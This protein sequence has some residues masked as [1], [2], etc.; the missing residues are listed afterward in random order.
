MKLGTLFV[1]MITGSVL[2][3]APAWVKLELYPPRVGL[4]YRDDY[5]RVLAVATRADGVTR[6]VTGEA[7]WNVDEAAAKVFARD[8]VGVV[9]VAGD[10]HAALKCEFA[11][12]S[13][14]LDVEV[15]GA[16]VQKPVSYRH[17][18]LPIFMRCGCN[19]GGCHGASLG[20]DGFRLSLFGFDPA[21]DYFRITQELPGRRLNLALPQDSL[22]L[23][24]AINS[25]PHTGGKRMEPDSVY[26]QRLRQW[27]DAGAPNDL[28]AAPTVT[29]LAIY[30]PNAVLEGTGVKQPFIAVAEY[31]DGSTRDVSNLV[32]FQSNNPV[33]ADISADGLTTSGARGEAFVM[34]RF[35][36]HTV[37]SQ[38]LVLPADAMYEPRDEKPA[39][40]ID[41]LVVAKLAKLRITPSDRCTD[42]EFLRRVTLDIVGCLPT[43]EEHAAFMADQAPE[44]R[45]AKIDELLARKEFADIWT[46]KL[47]QLLMVRTEQNRVEYK[48]MFLYFQ[49]LS[50][51]IADGMPLNEIVQELLSASGGSFTTPAV[52]FYQVEPD[53]KKIA[54]N[55]AQ[56]FLG[57]R[58]QCAQCHNHPFDRWTMDDYYA[59]SAFF[60]QIGRKEG[61]DYRETIVFNSG[62]GD[63]NHPVDGRAVPPKF[64][65]GDA[66]DLKG[67]DRR[68]V[69]AEWIA[70]A[71][72]PYFA[73]SIANRVWAHFFGIGIIEPVDDIRVSNPASNPELF[74]EL[75]AKLISYKYDLKALVR[76]ICNS[77][78]YQRSGVANDSNRDDL[79]NFS[80]AQPRRIPAETLLD[81]VCQAAA[82]P[83]KFGGLPL[84]ARATQIADGRGGN[85]FLTTFGRSKRETVCACEAKADPTLSQALH[86]LNGPTIHEKISQGKQ[87]EKWLDAGK[88][89]PEVIDSIYVACVSRTPTAEE[90]DKLLALLP[91]ENPRPVAELEDIFWAMLNSRE[92]VFNH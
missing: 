10:G 22:L 4:Y 6:D 41:E 15:T 61:E 18:V 31:S 50:R 76:D 32:V 3:D 70:S 12:L 19:T 84:G 37:G 9:R 42:E 60:E 73:P 1:L 56:A 77:N 90:R 48:P 25:A 71:E 49:W 28:A 8:E 75:G 39:N 2:A 72:N 89:P 63:S 91:K 46:M 7:N 57:L 69:A 54:E 21:A 79:R 43:V 13:A 86:L 47:A 30:P 34:A 26:Y 33:T 20:K 82:A 17:D 5:Q 88:T 58:I 11:G 52:N 38:V 55:V 66:P 35:D 59:F 23:T 64:L 78:A 62:A 27:I 24:K 67:R 53:P 29:N 74:A 44:K 80:H 51:R 40:Y 16:G 83:E 85:Y 45:A 81:C 92:F 14:Q 87:I 65:G 68:Q 36:T